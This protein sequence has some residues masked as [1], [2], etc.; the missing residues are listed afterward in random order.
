MAIMLRIDWVEQSSDP[1]LSHRVKRVG[2]NWD[3]FRWSHTVENAIRYIEE[4]EFCYF[5]RTTGRPRDL[6]VLGAADSFKYLAI[7]EDAVSV[8]TLLDLP[9]QPQAVVKTA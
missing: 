3:G 9:P 6:I 4:K 8:H 5:V 7:R 1:D 2:G